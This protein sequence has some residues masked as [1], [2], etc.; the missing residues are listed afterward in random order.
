MDE[1]RQL[2]VRLEAAQMELEFLH[3]ELSFVALA[4]ADGRIGVIHEHEVVSLVRATVA[5]RNT[6]RETH[7][8]LTQAQVVLTR[9]R[10]LLRTIIDKTYRKL[11]HLLYD[12]PDPECARC[13]T[14]GEAY[15][16]VRDLDDQKEEAT[17]D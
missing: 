13:Q 9:E 17:G 16:H 3:D 4:V 7:A 14:I 11:E 6:L 8:E 15:R 12:C 5:E 2:Q 10:D 1:D